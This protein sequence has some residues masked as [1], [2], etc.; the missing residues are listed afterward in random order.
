MGS[1]FLPIREE[2]E[3]KQWALEGE[4]RESREKE[5]KKKQRKKNKD[6]RGV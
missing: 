5:C 1:Y 6:S 3:E 2:R 4:L